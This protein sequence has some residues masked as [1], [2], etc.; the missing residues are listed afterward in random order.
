MPKFYVTVAPENRAGQPPHPPA[1]TWAIEAADAGAAADRA[2]AAYRRA[3]PDAGSLRI[4]VTRAT[5]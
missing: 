5:P 2:E 3:N 1:P 4:R